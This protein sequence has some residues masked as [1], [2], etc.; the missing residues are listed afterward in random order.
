M[1][2]TI[3]WHRLARIGALVILAGGCGEHTV[4]DA[5]SPDR[6]VPEPI[7]CTTVFDCPRYDCQNFD[8]RRGECVIATNVAANTIC[9]VSR[10]GVCNGEGACVECIADRQCMAP[11]TCVDEECE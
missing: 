6:S 7:P 4:V 1:S 8:C 3:P 9:A 10:T 2:M 11:Q 5:S